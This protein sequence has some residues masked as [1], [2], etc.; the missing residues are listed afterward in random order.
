MFNRLKIVCE[1]MKELDHFQERPSPR[2]NVLYNWG[3]NGLLKSSVNSSLLN[4]AVLG[5]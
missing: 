2:G 4:T 3:F 5:L 1:E